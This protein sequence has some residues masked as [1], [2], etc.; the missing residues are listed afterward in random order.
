MKQ[1]NKYIEKDSTGSNRVVLSEE[2]NFRI[3]VGAAMAIKDEENMSGD[4]YSFMEL[5]KGGYMIALSDGMGSGSSAGEDSRTVIELLEQFSEVGFKRD[6]ALKMINSVLIMNADKESFATLDMCYIDMYSGV[7]EFIKT[8]AAA[9]FLIRDGNAKAIRS[10]SLPMGMLK[11]FDM[12][13]SEY[14][15]KK[16]DIILMLT[17]GAAEIIDRDKMADNILALMTKTKLKDPKDIAEYVLESL[18]EESGYRVQDDMT[19]VAVRVW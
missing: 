17:D 3:S 16:N 19:V 6:L 10:S 13:K 4:S 12:D 2:Y 15:L 18:K 9:T 5:P 7:A 1:T 11:Y 8:G 14:K